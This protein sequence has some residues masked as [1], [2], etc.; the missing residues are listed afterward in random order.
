MGLKGQ[1]NGC[2]TIINIL[3]YIFAASLCSF[4]HPSAEPLRQRVE[5]LIS[6]C[7][8]E[9]RGWGRGW[10]IK[11]FMVSYF[12]V[13]LYN[14]EQ[15]LS[16]IQKTN[17]LVLCFIHSIGHPNDPQC[18]STSFHLSFPPSVSQSLRWSVLYR[19]RATD[20]NQDAIDLF[21][22]LS[23]DGTTND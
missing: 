17:L 23:R 5:N 8:V 13:E 4:K 14:C 11:S 9:R 22:L 21:D 2:I 1:N 6:S 20:E 12:H 19:T 16:S 3:S 10:L 15:K 7:S 18:L